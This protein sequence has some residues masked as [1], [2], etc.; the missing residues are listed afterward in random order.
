MMFLLV[1]YAPGSRTSPVSSVL[2]LPADP[3]ANNRR[4][5]PISGSN[6]DDD[7]G[8]RVPGFGVAHGLWN[9]G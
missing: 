7:L 5:A 1:G 6:L 9:L 2:T 4:F 8:A 3:A